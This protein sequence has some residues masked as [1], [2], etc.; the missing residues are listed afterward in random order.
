MEGELGWQSPRFPPGSWRP[1]GL[2]RP[3]PPPAETLP[4][5]TPVSACCQIADP[6]VSSAGATVSCGAGDMLAPWL[7]CLQHQSDPSHGFLA[8]QRPGC[9]RQPHLTGG[10]APVEGGA[11]WSP[12]HRA[13]PI[14][15]FPLAPACL[16]WQG[17][18]PSL[19]WSP[20]QVDCL[21]PAQTEG[22]TESERRGSSVTLV[23]ILPPLSYQ[24]R[25][26]C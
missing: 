24:G 14:L 3:L 8:A 1:R 18:R 21:L 2:P 22:T 6:L 20:P 4:P 19:H 23:Q 10:S 11:A 16:Q 25:S 17:Q 5:K 26:Q 12:F 13:G 15:G 7:L 9:H